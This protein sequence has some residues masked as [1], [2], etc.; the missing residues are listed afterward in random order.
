MHATRHRQPEER[1]PGGIYRTAAGSSSLGV[2]QV[3]QKPRW[4][5][6]HPS[7]LAGLSAA[8]LDVI[9]CSRNGKERLVHP[10][11]A[12]ATLLNAPI[13]TV[14]VA[15]RDDETLPIAA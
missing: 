10:V 4:D 8:D 1:S 3:R 12:S 6:D 13:D 11:T 9:S 15:E 2:V 5:W 7:L 14:G